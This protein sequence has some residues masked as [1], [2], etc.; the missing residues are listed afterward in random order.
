M[1]KICKSIV[2]RITANVLK[3][4]YRSM[5]TRGYNMYTIEDENIP[6]TIEILCII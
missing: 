3:Q 5:Y 4:V 1:A 2:T 6:I